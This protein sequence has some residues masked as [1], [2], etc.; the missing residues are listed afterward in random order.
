M[1]GL[2]QFFS[3]FGSKTSLASKYPSPKHPRI[4]EP[5]AG[6]AGY[7]CLYHDRDVLLFEKD[8]V[9]YGVWD[10]LISAKKEYILAL[11]L[12][13]TEVA[14]LGTR[15][16]DFIGFW[17]ARGVTSPSRT[18]N[19]WGRSGKYPYSFW[20]EKTRERIANQ[21]DKIKHWRVVNGSY[22]QIPNQEATWFVDP[23]YQVAGKFYRFGSGGLDYAHL[24]SWVNDLSG[25]I[26]VCEDS[27]ADWLPFRPFVGARNCR[28]RAYHEAVYLKG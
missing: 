23:P 18:M 4:I 24:A 21:V 11:P 16:R 1:S 20:S 15:Q 13:P 7:S 2:R 14:N 17:F 5:F 8:P 10:Y 26:I 6:S 3:Y 12:D 19:A 25:Q 9:V 22:E 27:R 28:N